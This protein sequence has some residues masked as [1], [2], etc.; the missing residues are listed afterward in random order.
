MQRHAFNTAS[1]L[2]HTSQ[3][4][5]W[6]MRGRMNISQLCNLSAIIHVGLEMQ[7]GQEMIPHFVLTSTGTGKAAPGLFWSV[8]NLLI[9]LGAVSIGY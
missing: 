5:E 8:L 3:R 1:I 4:D 7:G 6:K 9:M 2:L